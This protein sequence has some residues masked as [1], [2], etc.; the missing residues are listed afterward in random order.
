MDI[1]I[2]HPDFKTQLLEMRISGRLLA[3][4][5][6]LNGVLVKRSKGMYSVLNDCG[7]EVTIRLNSS[8]FD[9]LPQLLIE[10][11]EIR[12]GNTAGWTQFTGWKR[13]LAVQWAYAAMK[14]FFT[15]IG[16]EKKLN[17]PA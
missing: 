17:E 16:V 10:H 3:P 12:I 1:T 9:R 5:I 2:P 4:R 7:H 13:P 11:E 6:L 15:R 14:S 8:V